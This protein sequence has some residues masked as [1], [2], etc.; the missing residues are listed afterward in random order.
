[1][2]N[3]KH[4]IYNYEYNQWK[5]VEH[6]LYK[7]IK[8]L[9]TEGKKGKQKR[10]EIKNILERF[11][12]CHSNWIIQMNK[13]VDG[14]I[15]IDMPW[16]VKMITEFHEKF[17]LDTEDSL[18]LVQSNIIDI[19]NSEFGMQHI[20]KK[21]IDVSISFN[22]D[23]ISF[24]DVSISIG[25]KA[26]TKLKLGLANN[27][28]THTNVAC[29]ILKY[30]A[31]L[32]G[33]QQWGVPSQVFN[34][35][36]QYFGVRYEAFACPLNSGM[37]LKPEGK[38][39]SLFIDTDQVFGSIGNF[40]NIDLVSYCGTEGSIWFMNP[41]FIEDLLEQSLIKVF[42]DLK[43]ARDS[44]KKLKIFGVMPGWYDSHFYQLLRNFW[45]LRYFEILKI[46]KHFYSSD[47]KIVARF[48]SVVYVLDS[49]DMTPQENYTTAFDGMRVH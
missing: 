13:T 29:M 40:F 32:Y 36:Y 6:I 1:M 8:T 38:F 30:K 49:F 44:N 43:Q 20:P 4:D 37:M 22:N 2:N 33:S 35:L 34:D 21:H 47:R 27:L 9:G 3:G 31:H 10:Y 18:L 12:I 24:D 26:I 15:Q 14:F 28:W 7:V 45:G 42:K 39:C 5:L 23:V 19:W 11:L 46:N 16:V 41:P 48:E 17:K 25:R